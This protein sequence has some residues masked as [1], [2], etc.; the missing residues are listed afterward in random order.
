MQTRLRL[1]VFIFIVVNIMVYFFADFGSCSS[2]IL[3]F[4]GNLPM[5]V[6]KEGPLCRR[7]LEG[8]DNMQMQMQS[9][10]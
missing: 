2:F 7:I 1:L 10:S 4:L 3:T 5:L 8:T 9:Q 6:R